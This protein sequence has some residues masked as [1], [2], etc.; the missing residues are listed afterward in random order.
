MASDG[1]ADEPRHEKGDKVRID[2]PAYVLERYPD[3]DY[4]V[5]ADGCEI[6]VAEDEV[7]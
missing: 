2:I 3:G 1:S 6:I 7:R 4:L 5:D